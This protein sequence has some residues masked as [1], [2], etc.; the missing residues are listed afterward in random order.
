[1]IV[2]WACGARTPKLSA[3]TA[4]I[5]LRIWYSLVVQCGSRL[6]RGVWSAVALGFGVEDVP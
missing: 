1:M 3:L 2:T 6:G 5:N 4:A